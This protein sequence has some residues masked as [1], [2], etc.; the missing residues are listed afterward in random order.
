MRTDTPKFISIIIPTY[1]SRSSLEKLLGSLCRQTYPMDKSEVIVVDDGSLDN[2][3]EM[4]KREI[5]KAPFVLKYFF[6]ENKGPAAARNLGIKNSK[7]DV[8]VFTDSDCIVSEKWLAE[9]V[10][11]YDDEQVAATGGSILA[12]PV[13]SLVSR[14]CAYI[15]MNGRPEIKNGIVSYVITGNASFRKDIL[16]L[17]RGFDERFY[18]PGGED[19]DIC[20]RI[21]TKGYNLIYNPDAIVFNPHKKNIKE[22]MKTYFNYGKGQSFLALKEGSGWG[23]SQMRGLRLYVCYL[24]ITLNF[25]LMILQDLELIFDLFKIPLNALSYYGQKG[26]PVNDCLAY[27]LLDFLKIFSFRQGCIAGYLKGKLLGLKKENE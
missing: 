9:L 27:S 24:K 15:G 21:I 14:Y 17:I 8:V 3:S 22:L 4:V 13:N 18:F 26:L 5:D 20:R 23:L 11:G 7:G 6:Q 19:P 10:K 12:L 25:G 2:T 1:N 16:V